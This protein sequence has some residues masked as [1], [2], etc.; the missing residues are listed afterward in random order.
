MTAS[1]YK[2]DARNELYPDDVSPT[3]G[4][5]LH[6]VHMAPLKNKRVLVI[7]DSY[8]WYAEYALKQGAA[9]VHS[10]DIATPSEHISKLQKTYPHFKHE[11]ISV[12]DLKVTDTYDVAGYFE[13]IE[14]LPPGTEVD[15]L[16][17]IAASLSKNG[18]LL[19]STPHKSLPS[20]LADPACFFGH[21]HYGM[22]EM[23]SL[24]KPTGLKVE[25]IYRG[26]YIYAMA[27]I[28]FLYFT[29]WVLRK[30]YISQ[31]LHKSDR[32]Y[33]HPSGIT[34]FVIARK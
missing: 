34:L 14:H 8:G 4:R 33:P 12:F 3:H 27:D 28:L 16:Q 1:F 26:G 7:G 2:G 25:S 23:S 5:L 17:K 22:S 11:I 20:Y 6:T 18:V 31:I 29:K 21:R 13:V 30:K 9:Y 32:E 10:F 15:S 19:L 24:L